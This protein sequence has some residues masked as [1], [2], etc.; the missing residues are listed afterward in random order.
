MKILFFLLFCM[1]LPLVSAL[2]C[3]KTIHP[4]YCNDIQ[5]SDLSE[6][7]KAY[8]LSDIFSDKKTTPDHA[9]IKTWNEKISTTTKPDGVTTQ[10]RGYIKNAWMKVLAVM[11]SV[12]NNGTL[13]I[14][15]AGKVRTGFK[16]EVQI[17]SST[18]SGDCRT[19]RILLEDKGTLSLLVNN[20][21]VGE[22]SSV[23][24]TANYPHN[25]LVNIKAV[26]EV[27][28]KT[29]IRHYT[30]QRQCYRD[31]CYYSCRYSYT[32]YKTDSLSLTEIVPTK[33]YNPILTASFLVKDRYKDTIIGDFIFSK[34]AVNVQ[35]LF[36]ESS[37]RYHHY[38]FSEQ[39]GIVP[40]NV[41]TEKAVEK[42]TTEENNLA[43]TNGE[44]VAP[45]TDSCKIKI[46]GFFKEKE[47]P[48][49]LHFEEVE[50]SA[51][52]D[53]LI[54]GEEELITLEI[55]PAGEE[56]SVVYDGERYTTNGKVQFLARK[57]DNRIIIHHGTRVIH[58]YIHV[59]NDQPLNAAFS[60]AIFG[61]INYG[62][63]GL[64][65]KYWGFVA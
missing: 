39:Y 48:C 28:V 21:K 11:P 26:Y 34:E 5:N 18:A 19:Y 64:I 33:V 56:Y 6:E 40:L 57:E 24:F 58:Q 8:L 44:I 35:L 1:F 9:I 46:A 25:T 31:Y 37:Y 55:Q 30:K 27:I 42:E 32:E 65:R 62:I 23:S 13:Y 2:D 7:E 43:Y 63:F 54:Y 20:F 29:K 3:S 45:A 4:D 14:D 50:I 61:T 17:P 52:T 36:D 59:K 60:L 16:H 38:L 12:L 53:K 49:N 41:F 51:K 22:G 10:N 47:L 15:T